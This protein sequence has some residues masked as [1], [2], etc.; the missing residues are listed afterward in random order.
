MA[1]LAT[2]V[3]RIEGLGVSTSRT[4]LDILSLEMPFTQTAIL[5]PSDFLREARLRSVHLVI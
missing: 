4:T 5:E 3:R 1:T 2:H